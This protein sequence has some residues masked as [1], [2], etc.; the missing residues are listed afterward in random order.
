MSYRRSRKKTGSNSYR[1]ETRT[2]GKGTRITNTTKSNLGGRISKTH[3]T[4]FGKDGRLKITD[5][6]NDNGLITRVSRTLGSKPK[7][8]KK[9]RGSRRKSSS[10]S[11]SLWLWIIIGIMLMIFIPASIPI[12]LGIGGLF[13]AL[14]ILWMLL[15]YLIWGTVIFILIYIFIK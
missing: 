8:Y 13:L 4:S 6:R 3:S 14:S 15:P 12:V 2:T 1:T 11:F 10:I 9:P 5:T 7:T